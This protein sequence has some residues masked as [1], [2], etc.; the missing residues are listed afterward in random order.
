MLVLAIAGYTKKPDLIYQL[1]DRKAWQ[2]P[3]CERLRM[4]CSPATRDN[5]IELM[6]IGIV[7]FV[8]LIGSVHANFVIAP[9]LSKISIDRIA[10]ALQVD[11]VS[12]PL[13]GLE[14]RSTMLASLGSALS[15]NP[16]FFGDEGRPG[17][18]IGDQES[19]P[20]RSTITQLEINFNRLPLKEFHTAILSIG[21]LQGRR[22]VAVPC[23]NSRLGLNLAGSNVSSRSCSW[24]CLA[25]P[26]SRVY[27][28]IIH[29][30]R[31]IGT[32]P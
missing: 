2:S 1:D 26:N 16:E 31:D 14:G 7:L 3:V 15:K 12:N 17:N 4:V 19:I 6:V 25:L 13:N 21:A 27:V 22:V 24:G 10:I 23:V 32:L 20:H 30:G 29:C 8:P 9:G 18:M 11:S 28:T 5:H